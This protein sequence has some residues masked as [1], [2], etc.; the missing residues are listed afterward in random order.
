MADATSDE[1][2]RKRGFALLS[3]DRQREIAS[4][5]GKSVPAEKRAFSIKRD[6]ASEAGRN[7]GLT[8]GRNR[9]RARA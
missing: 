8:L 1:P 7:G 4:Q 3:P 6:L 5:G 2:K 9:S